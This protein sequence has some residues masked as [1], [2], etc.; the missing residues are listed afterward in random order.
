MKPWCA[1]VLALAAVPAPA[2]P[3][4]I[5]MALACQQNLSDGRILVSDGALLPPNARYV[6]KRCT[7]KTQDGGWSHG[8]CMLS[9]TKGA[10][11]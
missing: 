11:G 6:I 7:P 9:V 8:E 4:P 3:A 2:A 5:E 10:S 1:A